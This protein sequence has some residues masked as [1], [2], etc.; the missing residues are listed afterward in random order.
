M[1]QTCTEQDNIHEIFEVIRQVG[2]KWGRGSDESRAAGLLPR[3]AVHSAD[4]TVARCLSVR[5]SVRH[6]P[7]FCRNESSNCFHRRVASHHSSF[8]LPN[9]MAIFRRGPPNGASN[10]RGMKKI[11]IFIQC[12]Y[13]SRK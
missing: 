5:L 9:N 1:W 2:A 10:S 7:V 4:Y 11:A 3:D 12:L 13:L 6:T 8:C